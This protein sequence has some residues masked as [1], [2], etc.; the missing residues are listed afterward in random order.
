MN[1][2]MKNEKGFTL[3]EIIAVLVILGIMA[4]VAVPKYLS[5]VEDARSQSAQG[6]IAE[7]KGRLSAAQ[8]KYM[9]NTGGTAPSNTE[10]FTYATGANGYGSAANLTNLGSDFGVTVAS[11]N[12]ITISVTSVGGQPASVS[13]NFTA[14]K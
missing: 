12:P 4:A 10:L 9:M 8:A 11:G 1:M 7:V 3:V 14:A 2:R 13:G 5:M 6:A